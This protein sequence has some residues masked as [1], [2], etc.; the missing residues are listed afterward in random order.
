MR[1][2]NKNVVINL[3][4]DGDM[5]QITKTIEET[6]ELATEQK[7]IEIEEDK[8]MNDEEENFTLEEPNLAIKSKSLALPFAKLG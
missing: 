4:F 5:K 2:L 1:Q 6:E 3:V 7:L 8:E